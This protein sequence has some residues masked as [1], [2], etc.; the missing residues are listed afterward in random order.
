MSFFEYLFHFVKGLGFAIGGFI[1]LVMGAI[2]GNIGST[3]V[4]KGYM[5]TTELNPISS[6]IGLIVIIIGIAML[7]YA[8]KHKN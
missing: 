2:I 7:G 8:W 3:P 1:L 4:K 5:T 6:I